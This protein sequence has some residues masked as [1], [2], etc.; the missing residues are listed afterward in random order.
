[1]NFFIPRIIEET[2]RK[3]NSV[4]IV[5]VQQTR[6]SCVEHTL[7]SPTNDNTWYVRRALEAF[8]K[9]SFYFGKDIMKYG[10]ISLFSQVDNPSISSSK[11]WTV[12]YAKLG[13]ALS[14]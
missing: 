13:V 5:A 8:I 6:S 14:Y 4:K 7:Q 11:F 1:M 3:P 12:G 10:C 2:R 9:I